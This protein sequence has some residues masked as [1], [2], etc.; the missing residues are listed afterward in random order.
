MEYWEGD[1]EEVEVRSLTEAVV[2]APKVG[3]DYLVV[4]VLGKGK[5]LT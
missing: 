4:E 5:V 2:L 1:V 3:F